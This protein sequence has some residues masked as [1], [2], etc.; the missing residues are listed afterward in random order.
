M[1]LLVEV[2]S[3]LTHCLQDKKQ[4]TLPVSNLQEGLEMLWQ[5]FPLLKKNCL[6]RNGNIR[7]HV[8]IFFNED[9]I[10]WLDTLDR[11]VVEGDRLT[12]LQAVS[13]GS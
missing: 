10:C 2:P 3:M 12:I 5:K 6:T 1:T 4:I 7:P 8:L 13:G 11:A 9:N